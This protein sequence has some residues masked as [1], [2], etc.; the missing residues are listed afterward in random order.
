MMQNCNC[1]LRVGRQTKSNMPATCLEDVRCH[2]VRERR[3]DYR[4]TRVRS[5]SLV[6]GDDNDGK[7]RRPPHDKLS[8]RL[9]YSTKLDL[10]TFQAAAATPDPIRNAPGL[11]EVSKSKSHCRSRHLCRADPVGVGRSETLPEHDRPKSSASGPSA[12]A[13][14]ITAPP[15]THASSPSVCQCV[16]L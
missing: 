9:P 16:L 6:S 4:S 5:G 11:A 8:V 10:P 1:P 7:S 3:C 2:S 13:D 12:T 14:G 15:V